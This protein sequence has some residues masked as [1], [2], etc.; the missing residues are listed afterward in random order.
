MSDI[1]IGLVNLPFHWISQCNSTMKSGKTA[2]CH[3]M[4]S[5]F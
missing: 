3:H 5:E 2:R 1:V 4:L